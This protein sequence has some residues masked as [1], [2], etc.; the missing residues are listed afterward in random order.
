MAV[1]VVKRLRKEENSPA[2]KA[3]LNK[4]EE[5][6]EGKRG[7]KAARVPTGPTRSFAN[8]YN[9]RAQK[10]G[11]YGSSTPVFPPPQ[12]EPLNRHPEPR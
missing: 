7:Q 1:A 8:R 5:N 4:L 10:K 9:T 6:L 12:Q 11:K 2:W 3:N